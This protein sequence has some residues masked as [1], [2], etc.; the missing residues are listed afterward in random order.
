MSAA[1]LLLA[2][3]LMSNRSALINSFSPASLF[4]SGEQGI[5]L[6]PSDFSTMFQDNLGATPVTAVGQ[7]VGLVMDKSQNRALG[8]ELI[9]NGS[10]ASGNSGWAL[11]GVGNTTT[12]NGGAAQIQGDTAP[13]IR[14]SGVLTVGKMYQISFRVRRIAGT[15][16]P[17]VVP[18]IL[19]PV[20]GSEWQTI[21]QI[22][23]AANANLD[24]GLSGTATGSILEVTDISAKE[25]LG[26]HATQ[27]TAASRP[28]LGR[29]PASGVRNLLNGGSEDL[30]NTSVW[31]NSDTLNGTRSGATLSLQSSEGF[32]AIARGGINIPATGTWTFSVT[33]VC[34][35]T[36]AN[37]PIRVTNTN[38]TGV[39]YVLVNFVAGVPQRIVIPAIPAGTSSGLKLSLD[40]RDSITPGS[41]NATG[42]SVTFDQVQVEAGNVATAYQKVGS[43][44]WDV[45]EAGQ[46]DCYYLS[47]DGVDDF[48]VTSTVTPGTDKAQ[49]FLGLRKLSD[50]IESIPV[51]FGTA[52]TVDGTF[53]I[54]V[55]GGASNTEEYTLRS[56]GQTNNR[57]TFTADAAF[58]APH[59][60]VLG[61]L[62][63][64]A[65]DNATLR[66]NGSIVGSTAQDQGIS[67][68]LPYPLYIG[69]RAGSSG[70]FNGRIYSLITRF[71]P[72]LTAAQIAQTEAWAN[73]KTRAY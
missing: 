64:I 12:F 22:R 36:I 6:D 29:N 19:L 52:S 7:T 38:S 32:V 42:Y 59:T 66:V 55:A 57:Y 28:I 46:P 67:N 45:T 25:V 10:F 30:A 44:S 53:S 37:V 39:G 50:A 27:G 16:V 40:A 2:T 60:A 34:D 21:T 26:N 49:A 61:G 31:T 3:A 51:E 73:S 17:F 62:C 15:A 4:T 35:Q 58:N 43:S 71:G 68:F 56:R 33:A 41:T 63:D 18:N 65:G 69:R 13:G 5:W 23:A 24:V 70:A 14:R 47:F 54:A 20:I 1:T 48:L 72:N 11:L 8:P 9:P